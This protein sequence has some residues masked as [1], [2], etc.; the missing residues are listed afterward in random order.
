MSRTGCEK[1]TLSKNDLITKKSVVD[2]YAARGNNPLLTKTNNTNLRKGGTN[3][4]NISKNFGNPMGKILL[5]FFLIMILFI[6]VIF[7]YGD[8]S[9]MEHNN[10]TEI[11]RVEYH[12]STVDQTT[13]NLSE[14]EKEL[15]VINSDY[16][17]EKAAK[18]LQIIISVIIIITASFFMSLNV[19][20]EVSKYFSNH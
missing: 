17:S 16:L 7:L 13:R 20:F 19:N 5:S 14:Y 12:Y 3:S 1:S 8:L 11:A 18:Q 9:T 6:N 15:I 2:E 4:M 10:I